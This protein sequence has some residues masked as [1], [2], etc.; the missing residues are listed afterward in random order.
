MSEHKESV[1]IQGE[2]VGVDFK[3]RGN[4]DKHVMLQLCIED[5]G[6]WYPKDFEVS[7][8]WIDDMIDVLYKAKYALE[9]S[10]N[11][12]KDGFGYEFR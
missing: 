7:S 5:D 12:D 1:S 2:C 11:K 9:T 10:C 4:N 6:V 8:F 3:Q